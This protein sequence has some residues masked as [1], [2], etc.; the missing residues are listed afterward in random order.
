M[1]PLLFQLLATFFVLPVAASAS[2]QDDPGQT[3]AGQTAAD[4]P[5]PYYLRRNEPAPQVQRPPRRRMVLDRLYN[6]RTR[7]NPVEAELLRQGYDVAGKL[8]ILPAKPDRN[9]TDAAGNVLPS[10]DPVRNLTSPQ[11]RLPQTYGLRNRLTPRDITRQQLYRGP[12]RPGMIAPR[13]QQ[14]RQAPSARELN[15]RTDSRSQ[16]P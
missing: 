5:I 10:R 9:R 13:A 7:R 15:R 16:R 1:R 6:G 3:L 2:G 14:A 12:S 4:A 8:P 11:L